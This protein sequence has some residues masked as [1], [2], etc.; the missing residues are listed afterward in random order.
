[1]AGRPPSGDSVA[2]YSMK[3][4]VF[5]PGRVHRTFRPSAQLGFSLV[6]SLAQTEY[7]RYTKED[8]GKTRP[9]D[10]QFIIRMD[11]PKRPPYS[12]CVRSIAESMG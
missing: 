4:S 7:L 8:M 6:Q 10:N 5:Q 12:W 3:L 9:L 11:L 1:M 2:E